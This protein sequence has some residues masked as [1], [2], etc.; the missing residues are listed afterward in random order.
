MLYRLSLPKYETVKDYEGLGN[1]AVSRYYKFPF[2]FFYCKKL[3]LILS[4]LTK[5]KV[6]RN[7]LDYGCGK[8]NIFRE[9][10][11]KHSLQVKCIDVGDILDQRW[12]FDVVVCASVLEFVNLPVA[13]KLIKGVIAPN[14]MIVASSPMDT[15]LSRTY[16]KIID[17]KSVRHT[18]KEIM[19]EV[20][21]YYFVVKYKEWFG[22]YF[23]FKAYPK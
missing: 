10:L 17:D 18:H 1:F 15:W 5:G 20:H 23:S 4:L 11:E 21:K 16:F 8:A 7:I 2:S 3:Q 22:L 12:K 14:G 13:L 9:E 6:Y 19:E